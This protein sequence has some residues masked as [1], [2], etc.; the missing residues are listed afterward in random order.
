MAEERLRYVVLRHDGVA[1][2][3]YD[4]MFET[5][6][7]SSLATW[8]SGE[9]PPRPGTPLIHLNDHRAAYLSYEG[10][11]SG[12]RGF[13]RRVYSGFHTVIDDGPELLRV[14]LENNTVLTLYR[15]PPSAADVHPAGA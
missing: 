1:D 9:W 2:P 10:K 13:V 8:R 7:G 6:P 12:D 15:G 4:L 3:H 5:S 11:V 14:R